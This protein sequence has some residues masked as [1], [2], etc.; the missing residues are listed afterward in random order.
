MD[1]TQCKQHAQQNQRPS[2]GPRKSYWLLCRQL[3]ASLL[4]TSGIRREIAKRAK[5]WCWRTSP[6]GQ[7]GQRTNTKW[8]EINKRILK[9]QAVEKRLQ[10]AKNTELTNLRG[11][12][13]EL[14]A[15]AAQVQ[16]T[17]ADSVA[18]KPEKLSW[19]ILMLSR[20]GWRRGSSATPTAATA[21]LRLPLKKVFGQGDGVPWHPFGAGG[22]PGAPCAVGFDARLTQQQTWR[23][24]ILGGIGCPRT[25]TQVVAFRHPRCKPI[26][27]CF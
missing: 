8:T 23:T 5:E 12:T 16:Q 22:S 10:A 21:D 6:S 3:F 27:S 19:P 14:Q 13:K 1:H 9:K 15:E 4:S 17:V 18:N 2:Q 25:R 20:C 24:T 11:E 7:S 26:S